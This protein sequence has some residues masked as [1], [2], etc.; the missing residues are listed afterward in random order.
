MDLGVN[1]VVTPSHAT[2]SV[3]T[4]PTIILLGAAVQGTVIGGHQICIQL[5]L[6]VG[7]DLFD[8]TTV[9]LTII[10]H[11][12]DQVACLID[13]VDSFL[14]LIL[15]DAVQVDLV[16]AQLADPDDLAAFLTVG[17]SGLHGA[18]GMSAH[19]ADLELAMA[20]LLLDG[21]QLLIGF[22]D[23]LIIAA[24]LEFLGH[25]GCLLYL[26]I[27]ML[28]TRNLAWLVRGYGYHILLR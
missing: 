9:A 24:F 8:Q 12:L 3:A 6:D 10:A 4:V 15:G 22:D 20:D 18:L 26:R 28:H 2:I 11:Q 23:I 13:G 16:A 19:G 14:Q 5:Q 1:L 7:N 17:Q 25:M 21:G 27:T